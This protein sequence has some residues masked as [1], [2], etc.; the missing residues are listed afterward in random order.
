MSDKMADRRITPRYPLILRAELT[1]LTGGAKISA[2][3]SDLSRTGCYVD[4]LE[5]FRLGTV[6]QIKL[7]RGSESFEVQGTVRYVS[8]GLGMGVRFDEQIPVK[9]LA[10]LDRWLE[11]GAKQPV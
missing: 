6:I 10:I 9:Q 1:E 5:P 4:T 7:T 8:P 2:R 3:T 11:V